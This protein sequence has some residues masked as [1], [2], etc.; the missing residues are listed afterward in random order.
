MKLP[1]ILLVSVLASQALAMTIVKDGKSDF[2]IVISSK[3]KPAEKRA[4]NEF[5]SHLKQMSGAEL[6][7]RDDT[8]QPPAHAVIIGKSRYAEP[9]P[10]AEV[11]ND[12][13][14]L[15]TAGSDGQYLVIAGPGP[16]GSMY[17]VYEAL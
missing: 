2:V 12:G 13:F 9:P 11:G 8:G 5:Q 16:R 15:E 17:G 7:I 1:I 3:A 10:L 4:A 6:P 14:L